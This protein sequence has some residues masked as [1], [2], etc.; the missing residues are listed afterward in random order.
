[1]TGCPIAVVG[2]GAVLPGAFTLDQ[3]WHN[4]AN[5]LDQTRDVPEGR[6]V[7]PAD[8][9][10]ASPA[11]FDQ[12]ASRRGAFVDP[13]RLDRTGLDLDWNALGELDPLYAMALQA[14]RAAWL[15]ARTENVDRARTQVIL[16]AFSNGDTFFAAERKSAT[17]VGIYRGVSPGQAGKLTEKGI[18]RKSGGWTCYITANH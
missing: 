8:L 11:G 4:L 13:F 1:M 18:M 17:P 14:G 16:A 15:D 9:A 2:L 6:W 12:V 7:M 10:H 5:R 3:Y